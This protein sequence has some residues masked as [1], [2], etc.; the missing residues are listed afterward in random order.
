MPGRAAIDA[1]EQAGLR[2]ELLDGF[3]YPGHRARRMHTL[4]QRSGQALMAA[5]GQAAADAG[6]LVLTR[7]LARELRRRPGP[8]H[9]RDLRTTGRHA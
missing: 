2:F 6:A 9:G 3:L 4:R 5:L 8:D 7:T 1:L